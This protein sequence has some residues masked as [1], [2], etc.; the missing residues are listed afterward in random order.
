LTSCLPIIFVVPCTSEMHVHEYPL[1]HSNFP[2]LAI[3]T[4]IN[5]YARYTPKQ[6]FTWQG[7][8][9]MASSGEGGEAYEGGNGGVASYHKPARRFRTRPWYFLVDRQVRAYV[10]NLRL[11]MFQGSR[12]KGECTRI[13]LLSSIDSHNSN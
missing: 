8:D 6:P 4:T 3:A 2:L 5:R 10:G 9:I 13:V 11:V 12:R 1:P 7:P